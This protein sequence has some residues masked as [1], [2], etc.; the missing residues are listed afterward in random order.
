MAK[1]MRI[2]VEKTDCNMEP[3]MGKRIKL[4]PIESE[5]D[6][7]YL[8]RSFNDPIATGK[9]VNFKARGWQEFQ[10]FIKD[11]SKSPAHF[12]TF[13]IEKNDDKK[14]I[15]SIVYFVPWALSV[16]CFEIGYGID[17][18]SLRRKGYA[19]EAARLLVDY[20]FSMEPGLVRI[21]ATTDIENRGSQGVLENVGFVKEGITRKTTFVRGIF[22]DDVLYSLLREDWKLEEV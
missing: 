5:E 14:V 10:E 4:K 1:S 17:D 15:G 18:P 9:Y 3:L 13:L 22:R 21:Q 12:T 8:F 16:Q 6:M 11:G 20:L 7:K 19:S 2:R